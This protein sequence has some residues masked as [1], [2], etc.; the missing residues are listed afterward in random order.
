MAITQERIKEMYASIERGEKE[1][2]ADALLEQKS[3]HDELIRVLKNRMA[4]LEFELRASQKEAQD[5]LCLFEFIGE[6]Y[7][8]IIPEF[9]EYVYSLD[10][11]TSKKNSVRSFSS[12]FDLSTIPCTGTDF[13][14]WPDDEGDD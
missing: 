9:V 6:H 8:D 14:P 2:L 11:V 13:Q 4:D 10:N 5:F 1:R 7:Q 3:A 12:D